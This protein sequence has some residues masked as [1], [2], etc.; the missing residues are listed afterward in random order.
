[1]TMEKYLAKILANVFTLNLME[2]TNITRAGFTCTLA[3]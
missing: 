2:H 3:L 1:M